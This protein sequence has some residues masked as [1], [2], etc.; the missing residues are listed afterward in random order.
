MADSNSTGRGSVATITAVGCA[1]VA[2]PIGLALSPLVIPW[3][4]WDR[5]RE[6]R[7]R[8]QIVAK[9]GAHCRGVLVYSNSPNWQQYIETHWLPRLAGRL[10]VLN[11]SERATWNDRHPLE[12]KLVKGLGDRDFN[13]AAIILTEPP[14]PNLLARW[15]RALL[16]FDGVGILVPGAPSKEVIRFFKPFRDLKHGKH[17]TLRAAED[18][19]WMLLDPPP[20]SDRGA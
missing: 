10:V 20:E 3:I 1:V 6:G 11:W 4:L 16:R 13:P 14:D 19:M 9:H 2:I 15:W 8:R 17:H 18:R 7:L 12:T 5:R